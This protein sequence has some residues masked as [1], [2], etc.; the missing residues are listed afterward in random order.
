MWR[1]GAEVV[2]EEAGEGAEEAAGA[3]V[4]AA[5]V[6]VVCTGRSTPRCSV[7]RSPPRVTHSR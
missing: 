6:G 5:G 4:G 2:G 1:V 3:E 7:C